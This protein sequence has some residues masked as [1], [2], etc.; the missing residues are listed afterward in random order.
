MP[1]NGGTGPSATSR[2]PSGPT[3][4]A[5]GDASDPSATEEFLRTLET[6]DGVPREEVRFGDRPCERPEPWRTPL[7]RATQPPAFVPADPAY[8]AWLRS[9][10]ADVAQHFTLAFLREKIAGRDG[11]ERL[12]E[13]ARVLRATALALAS[14]DD[15]WLR[16]AGDQA[17]RFLRRE[18][19]RTY[20][21]PTL[22]YADIASRS[23]EPPFVLAS[24]DLVSATP[25]AKLWIRDMVAKPL[26]RFR[27][28]TAQTQWLQR[29]A[30]EI[31]MLFVAAL[32]A[33][34]IVFAECS[35]PDN[36]TAVIDAFREALPNA[37][38][39]VRLEEEQTSSALQQES[40]LDRFH[41]ENEAIELF[42]EQLVKLG[43]RKLGYPE[44]Q[45]RNF[46][47]LVGKRAKKQAG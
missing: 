28:P 4:A 2:A 47:S 27:N 13:T 19:R 34:P 15:V 26:W 21:V 43:L 12:L 23:Y 38:R 6:F 22:L 42:A 32:K 3:A 8:D 44:R 10:L 11:Q 40:R 45:V 35:Q 17:R 18:P 1:P 33:H 5:D 31:A 29:A 14:T 46:F 39:L 36:E 37:P 30:E 24:G 16:R 7:E 41:R 9:T 20:R 25:E